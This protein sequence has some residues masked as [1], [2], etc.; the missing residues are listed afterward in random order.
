MKKFL[1][2]I[3]MLSV[4]VP[5]WAQWSDDFERMETTQGVVVQGDQEIQSTLVAARK[6]SKKSKKKSQ[7]T[8]RAKLYKNTMI[9]MSICCIKVLSVMEWMQV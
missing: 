9:S 4:V 7:Q 2:A 6:K 8:P 1:L 3:V 5:S